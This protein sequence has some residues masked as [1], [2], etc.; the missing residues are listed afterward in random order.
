MPS[1]RRGRGR[2]DGV[3]ALGAWT[4]PHAAETAG[5][6]PSFKQRFMNNETAALHATWRPTSASPSRKSAACLTAPW[7]RSARCGRC[8][9][10]L[11]WR[12]HSPTLNPPPAGAAAAAVRI[13]L[14]IAAL[15]RPPRSARSRPCDAPAAPVLIAGPAAGAPGAR[16]RDRAAGHHSA[17]Q[18]GGLLQVSLQEHG[19]VAE[20]APFVPAFA[21]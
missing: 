19:A 8:A 15:P 16:K 4:R 5:I 10:A 17:A 3:C 2:A 20:A 13:P 14:P 21:C 1:R 12:P 11:P 7:T 9:A 18:W 6:R